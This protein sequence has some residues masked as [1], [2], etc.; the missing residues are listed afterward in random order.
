[1][2]SKEQIKKIDSDIE[3]NIISLFTQVVKEEIEYKRNVGINIIENICVRLQYFIKY[4]FQQ[5]KIEFDR[6]RNQL[7][8]IDDKDKIPEQAELTIENEKK[9]WVL[10]GILLKNSDSL[11]LNKLKVQHTILEEYKQF[12]ANRENELNK[13]RST[14]KVEIIHINDI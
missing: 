11:I 6:K 12:L 14:N 3:G 1:M 2:I 7:Q 9:I 13:E 5:A 8:P 4:R 10:I